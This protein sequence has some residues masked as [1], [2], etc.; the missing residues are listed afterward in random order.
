M[1]DEFQIHTYIANVIKTNTLES[2]ISKIQQLMIGNTLFPDKENPGKTKLL[3]QIFK[4]LLKQ[5]EL[6]HSATKV[7]KCVKCKEEEYPCEYV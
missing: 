6:L 5:K 2:E 3:N 1:F 7:H 4:A